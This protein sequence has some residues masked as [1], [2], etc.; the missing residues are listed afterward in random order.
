MIGNGE[1]LLKWGWLSPIGVKDAI[2]TV[3]KEGFED[4]GK[5]IRDPKDGVADLTN[6]V[7]RF[8]KILTD[9]NQEVIVLRKQL[10]EAEV[11]ISAL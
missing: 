2:L 7:D 1:Y 4:H 8:S 11:K 5:D 3:V 9:L 6:P 10:R